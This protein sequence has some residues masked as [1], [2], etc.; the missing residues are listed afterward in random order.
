MSF[1]SVARPAA[2]DSSQDALCAATISLEPTR[3]LM[4]VSL[5]ATRNICYDFINTR[6]PNQSFCNPPFAIT[7]CDSTLTNNIKYYIR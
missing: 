2:A 4:G 1:D 7:I 5:P 6:L 3:L